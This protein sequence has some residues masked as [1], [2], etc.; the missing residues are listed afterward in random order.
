MEKM[1]FVLWKIWRKKGRKYL[2]WVLMNVLA[3]GLLMG[4]MQYWEHKIDT[5][6]L[7]ADVFEVEKVEA[8]EVQP[9]ILGEQ[10]QEYL[11]LKEKVLI[12]EK[13]FEAV[14]KVKRGVKRD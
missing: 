12:Q 14:R 8:Q 3:F 11:E 4:E 13:V 2:V 9:E 7:R 10:Y 1:E 6:H 5:P